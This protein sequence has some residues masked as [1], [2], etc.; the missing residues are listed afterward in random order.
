L[1]HDK[2]AQVSREQSKAATGRTRAN[3]RSSHLNLRWRDAAVRL[4]RQ[5]A[6]GGLVLCLACLGE[7]LARPA[8]AAN[9]AYC[10]GRPTDRALTLLLLDTRAVTTGVLRV[11]KDKLRSDMHDDAIGYVSFQ[12]NVLKNLGG[13]IPNEIS[14]QYYTEDAWHEIPSE[15]IISLSGSKSIAF[16]AQ[17]DDGSFYFAGNTADALQPATEEN[18]AAVEA[19]LQRQWTILKRWKVDR[20]LPHYKT[21]EILIS[22][23]VRIPKPKGYGD[24]DPRDRQYAIFRQLEGL[25]KAAVPAIVAQ[26]DDRRPLAV[27]QIELKS[28]Y[29][30]AFEGIRHYAPEAVV[31][32]LANI[33]NQ[34]EGPVFDNI[35]NGGTEKARRSTINAWRVYVADLLCYGRP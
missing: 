5:L 8:W 28:N 23:L 6:H 11:N 24:D 35:L 9:P 25:G 20:T 1:H 21:V 26:M 19:E 3:P 13:K 27:H 12:F 33:L 14:I 7:P 30:G 22:E 4:I 2:R 16:L 29:P 15:K 17:G 18:V 32:A 31:D 34:V 10:V